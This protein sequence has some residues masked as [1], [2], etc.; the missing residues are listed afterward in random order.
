M[1]SVTMSRRGLLGGL[2]ATGLAGWTFGCSGARS[3]SYDIEVGRDR[4]LAQRPPRYRYEIVLG[5]FV[6]ANRF[7]VE[8]DV[9]EKRSTVTVLE[10]VDYGDSSR[11]DSIDA[12]FATALQ[13][14][15]NGGT[16]TIEYDDTGITPAVVRTDPLPGAIDDGIDYQVFAFEV[17]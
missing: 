14:R 1:K 13:A 5:G 9:L 4:W 7:R 16:A 3:N 2:A 11:W 17:M 12:L 15:S 6:L 10:G 8:V